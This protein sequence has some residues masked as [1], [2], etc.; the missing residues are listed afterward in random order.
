[1]IQKR[2][3]LVNISVP[4]CVNPCGWRP[5]CQIIVGWNKRRQDTYMAAVQQE[6]EANAQQF[7]DVEVVAVRFG[8]GLASNAGEQ[9]SQTMRV[10]RKCFNVADDVSITMRSA[11]SNISGA[12]MPWFKRAGIQRFDFEMMSMNQADFS[13]LNRNDAWADFVIIC[14]YILKTSMSELLGLV[15]SWGHGSEN[16]INAASVGNF[17]KSVV[18]AATTRASHI[19]LLEY[20][21]KDPAAASAEV[22]LEQLE[23]A[24]KVFAERGFTEYIPLHFGRGSFTR[25]RFFADRAAG[26]ELL[27]FGLGAQT[28]FDG[29]R[30]TNTSNLPIYLEGSADYSRITAAV[31]PFDG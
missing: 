11:I 15:L 2:S 30:S 9:V 31:E 7:P 1:M 23:T 26:A 10:L 3:V 25:D 13:K 4:F 12:N 16:G 27:G 21:G 19:R 24:R 28:C 29:V 18:E 5:Q 17:R 20:Q 14:D 8:D 22:Q 6:I